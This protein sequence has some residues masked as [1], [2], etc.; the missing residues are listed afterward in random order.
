MVA[1]S[2]PEYPVGKTTALPP[3]GSE[4]RTWDRQ[5][6]LT[7]A[8]APK[9]ISDEIRRS[10]SAMRRYKTVGE[11]VYLQIDSFELRLC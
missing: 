7:E 5:L 6:V 1:L 8:H 9:T 3:L 2:C 4:L 11:H 10:P